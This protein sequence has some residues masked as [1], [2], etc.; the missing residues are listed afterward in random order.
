MILTM[1]IKRHLQ[2]LDLIGVKFDVKNRKS[3]DEKMTAQAQ[4]HDLGPDQ[5]RD[6]QGLHH[7]IGP[8][9]DAEVVA[10]DP[11]L[12][13]VLVLVLVDQA[14]VFEDNYELIEKRDAKPR[15]PTINRKG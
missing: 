2:H 11:I 9:R 8:I 15:Q 4:D 3:A 12:L 1:K 14:R 7:Q 5:V 10:G 13:A 6:H